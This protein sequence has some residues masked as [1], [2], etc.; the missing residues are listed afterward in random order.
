MIL[1]IYTYGNSILRK[2]AEPIDNDYA[3]HLT[4]LKKVANS[5][6]QEYSDL[7]DLISDMYET[8]YHCGGIGLAA[9]QIG[10][11]IRILVID[12]NEIKDDIPNSDELKVTMINPTLIELS[13]PMITHEEGCL[14]IPGVNGNV[15]RHDTVKINYF[16]EEFKEHTKRHKWFFS[17]SYSTRIR[18]LRR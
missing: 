3:I 5:V 14:S 9:P 2:V 10:K 16:D 17:K 15:P 6:N 8:M 18:S 13:G 4:K 12:L 11:S 1:P 7:K